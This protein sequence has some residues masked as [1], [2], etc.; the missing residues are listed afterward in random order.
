[1]HIK[2]VHIKE[3]YTLHKIDPSLCV[4]TELT[5]LRATMLKLFCHLPYY[6]KLR[7]I[8]VCM[9]KEGSDLSKV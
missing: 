5:A 7:P 3:Y 2:E 8:A 6:A 4:V 9:H 1:V